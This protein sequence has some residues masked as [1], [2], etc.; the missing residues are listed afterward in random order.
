MLKDYTMNNT[1][2]RTQAILKSAERAIAKIADP[3]LRAK[4]VAR[5]EATR[6]QIAP[7][8]TRVNRNPER[9]RDRDVDR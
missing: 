5:L 2:K 8:R 3:T 6:K 9:T 4:A 7:M 1:Q